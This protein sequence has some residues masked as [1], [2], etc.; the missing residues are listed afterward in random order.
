MIASKIDVFRK[1]ALERLASIE[2]RARGLASVRAT[3]LSVS[4]MTV[5]ARAEIPPFRKVRLESIVEA[6]ASDS[7][8]VQGRPLFVK[9][10]AA[11]VSR[12]GK[13]KNTFYN[14]ISVWFKDAESKKNIKVFRNGHLHITGERNL[15]KNLEIAR[16]VIALVSKIV[17]IPMDIVDFDIQMINTNFKTSVGFILGQMREAIA[18]QKGIVKASY[19]PETYPGLNCKYRVGCT[20]RDISILAFNSGNVI[21]TGL[22][23]FSELEETYGFIVDFI[24][25]HATQIRRQTFT[26]AQGSGGIHTIRV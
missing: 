9:D 21:I 15:S 25:A 10:P 24:D 1:D 26:P 11:Q 22:K 23:A 14:Q 4:T 7:M 16:E 6:F 17:D 3:D 13:V 2:S 8:T 20:G 18:R 12:R 19:D 5:L